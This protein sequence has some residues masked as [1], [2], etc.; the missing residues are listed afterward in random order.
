MKLVRFTFFAPHPI[1]VPCIFLEGF[2][3]TPFSPSSWVHSH[4]PCQVTLRVLPAHRAHRTHCIIEAKCAS[5]FMDALCAPRAP[6][7]RH[8]HSVGLQISPAISSHHVELL[9][10]N[11]S[12]QLKGFAQCGTCSMQFRVIVPEQMCSDISD[13]ATV[14]LLLTV[15]IIFRMG[16]VSTEPHFPC[17]NIRVER[18]GIDA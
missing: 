2:F 4:T 12:L 14:W 6:R 9:D 15:A 13:N 1:S 11:P 17:D 7:G 18:F 10:L 8:P 3:D 5:G 16:K